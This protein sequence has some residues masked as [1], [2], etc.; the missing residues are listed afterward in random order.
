MAN[1]NKSFNFRN[2][3]QVD[4]DDLI[5]RSSLVGIGTTIPRADLDVYGTVR[6]TGIIT[7]NDLYV[8][9]VATFTNI[10]IGAGITIDGN[11]GIITASFAGDGS[12]LY[13]IPTSQWVDVDPAIY[14]GVGVGYS[15]IWAGGTV[16][17]GTTIPRS[18]LQVG[19]DPG[20]SQ[21]GVGISSIGDINASGIVTGGSFVGSG[22]DITNINASNIASGT[23]DT[24]RLSSNISVSGVVTAQTF[25]GQVN[26]GVATITTLSGTTGTVT[27]L[28]STNLS[29]TIG[30]VTTLESTT[31][32]V[33]NLT[34]TNLSGTIGTVTTLESTSG[35]IT[36]LSGTIGTVTTLSGTDLNY[37]GFGTVGFLTSTSANVTNLTGTIGTVTTLSGT[38]LNYTGFGTIGVLTATNAN[39]GIL[40]LTNST[41]GDIQLGVTASNQIDTSTGNLVLDS[42]G[43][44]VDIN[45]AIDVSGT[46]TLQGEVTVNTG[47]VPDTSTGAYLGQSGEEFSELWVDNIKIGVGVGNSNRIE[48]VTEDLVL[49]S[50]SNQ[51]VA[52]SNFRVVGV[53]TLS[54]DLTLGGGIEPSTDLNATLGTASKRFSSSQVASIRV[55]VAQTNEIDT[56]DNTDL[57]LDSSSGTTRITDDLLVSG[58]GSFGGELTAAIGLVPDTSK[59]AYLGTSGKP[60][61]EAFINDVTIGESNVN[62][63]DTTSG[64]LRINADSGQTEILTN[65][66]VSGVSTFS[67]ETHFTGLS[68]FYTGIVPDDNKGAFIGTDGKKFQE[69]YLNE[70]RIGA[71]GSSTIDTSV[72][73][74]KLSAN[75]NIVRVLNDLVVNNETTLRNDTFFGDSKFVVVDIASNFIGIGTS[76]PNERFQVMDDG[77]NL[78]AEFISRSNETD[79]G[80]GLSEVGAG[81]SV[82]VIGYALSTFNFTNEDVGGVNFTIHSGSSTGIGTTGFKW[83]YGQNSSNLMK[84]DYD[85]KLTLGNL[86]GPGNT[87]LSD[88]PA[89][90]AISSASGIGQTALYVEGETVLTGKSELIGIVSFKD[91]DGDEQ[92]ALSY[93]PANG[94]FTV[95]N[96]IVKGSTTGVTAAGSGVTV[97]DDTNNL[98]TAQI[99]NFTSGIAG[100]QDGSV[101]GQVNVSLASSI[102]S[103]IT[104]IGIGTTAPRGV[105]DLERSGGLNVISGS[106]VAPFLILPRISTTER[107][108]FTGIV[109]SMIYNTTNT[110]FE[111]FMDGGWCGISTVA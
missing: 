28:T 106:E 69:A 66:T 21:N 82:G 37:T 99:I 23:L 44:T 20:L 25:S 22:A 10:R 42:N 46:S 79:I 14:P 60:F 61:S 8:T 75:T 87:T 80:I 45:D 7:A 72:D 3:V 97:T 110:R 71:G 56:I 64:N 16:G 101:S 105:L 30:T 93:D 40:T 11:A 89:T 90:V 102:Y 6:S 24:A 2:G 12:G 52:D 109:G 9:G 53:T 63:I 36:N 39:I 68:T 58:I 57:V 67:Q 5:V 13:N 34:S 76:I 85:G 29:G 50:N 98:G 100:L 108:S 83:I 70:V 88:Y 84:L 48:T 81:S 86:F 4:E 47:I 17:I 19:G 35:T 104:Q 103:G 27:N 38:D 54:G 31:G 96:L 18:W 65:I 92:N 78:R 15:S 41:S 95:R 91:P 77:N 32:T 94:N 26:S 74:L 107:D 51:V 111:L 33:T 62:E 1:Y 73:D 55:G 43:G 59:G 49:D